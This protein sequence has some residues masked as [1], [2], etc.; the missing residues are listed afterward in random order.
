MNFQ[1]FIYKLVGSRILLI[2]SYYSHVRDYKGVNKKG[3]RPPPP[4]LDGI[5]ERV[6]ISRKKEY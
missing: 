1:L 3:G 4:K 6:N 5:W 2:H